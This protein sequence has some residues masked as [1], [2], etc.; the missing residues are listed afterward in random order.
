MAKQIFDTSLKCEGCLN[1]VRNGLNEKLGE[2]QWKVDLEA[3]VKTLEVD[4]KV[5]IQDLEPVFKAAG[6]EIKPQA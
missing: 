6:H 1:S 2:G 4:Q 3:A 5:S